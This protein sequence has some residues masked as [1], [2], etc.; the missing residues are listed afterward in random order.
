MT[1]VCHIRYQIDPHKR[2]G[3]EDYA[4]AWLAI[5]P[6]CGGR[7]IGYFM[8][9][10]GTNDI[11]HAMIGFDSLA[12]YEGYRARLRADPEARANFE[13]AERERLILREE[14]TFLRPVEAKP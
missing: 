9:H 2:A 3:F 10:E 11:A 1:V 12:A 7:L 5:I 13:F 8:P 4:R 14:R 6:G